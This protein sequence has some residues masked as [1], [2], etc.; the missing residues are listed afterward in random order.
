MP[1]SCFAS[2]PFDL[3]P[4]GMKARV[5]QTEF[6]RRRDATWLLGTSMYLLVQ[7]QLQSPLC[8][9]NKNDVQRSR[10]CVIQVRL[11]RALR[12][13]EE[14]KAK[15]NGHDDDK[16]PKTSFIDKDDDISIEQHDISLALAQNSNMA[17]PGNPAGSTSTVSTIMGVMSSA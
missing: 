17:T 11:R 6:N 10:N 13:S 14:Q 2:L 15:A 4:T 8:R 1:S 7:N 16:R 3:T 5:T 12:L 9:I